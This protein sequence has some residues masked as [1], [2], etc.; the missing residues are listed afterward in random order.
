[1]VRRT[2]FIGA[3]VM[4]LFAPTAAL[5][6]ERGE[7]DAGGDQ[8][9]APQHETD[10]GTQST[11]GVRAQAA[12][13]ERDR[14]RDRETDRP[15][16]R[17]TDRRCDKVTDRATDCAKDEV[18]RCDRLTD[19]VTDCTRIHDGDDARPTVRQVLKRCLWH[20]VGDRPIWEGLSPRE[21]RHLLHRCLWHHFRN[22]PP[23]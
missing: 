11:D 13:R 18:R 3:V 21:L 22:A 16:Q 6:G 1:M 7:M 17:E 10:V 9:A 15:P 12:D 23:V 8:G 19:R 20:H 4:A 14:Q 5:A 2:L